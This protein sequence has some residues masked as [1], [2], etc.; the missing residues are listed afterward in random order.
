ME[1]LMI[2]DLKKSAVRIAAIIQPNAATVFLNIAKIVPNIN[3][4]GGDRVTAREYL[5]RV[6]D[7]DMYIDAKLCEAARIRKSIS[8]LKGISYDGIRV[9]GGQGQGFAGAVDALLSLEQS[10]N[11]KVDALADMKREAEMK[12]DALPDNRFRAVLTKYYICG[13]TFDEMAGLKRPKKEGL[14]PLPYSRSHI[15]RLHGLA[16]ESFR[17]IHRMD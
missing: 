5:N 12:I 3:K 9:S 11:E 17:K 16:L 1:L 4:T 10:I 6:R 2:W 15:A 8:G 7:L 13:M 14:T